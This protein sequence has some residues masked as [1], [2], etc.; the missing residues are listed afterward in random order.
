MV[1]DISLYYEKCLPV[2]GSN[3]CPVEPYYKHPT[4]AICV[5][6][7]PIGFT[8]SLTSCAPVAFCH[9][10]C[11]ACSVKNDPTKCSSCS[12]SNLLFATPLPAVGTEGSCTV[13]PTDKWT[14]L[15]TIDK[16]TVL[17]TSLVK[18]ITYNSGT[19]Q[20]TSGFVLGT[21]YTQNVIDFVSLTSNSIRL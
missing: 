5:N 20:A 2:C 16:T 3:N 13:D 4:Q 7:C 10:T 9:S 1:Q 19:V 12:S 21:L 6:N 11:G 15:I 18:N 8:E 17:G 14:P